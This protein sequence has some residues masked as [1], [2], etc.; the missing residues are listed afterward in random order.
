MTFDKWRKVPIKIRNEF[1][2]FNITNAQEWLQGQEVPNV[3][4]VGPYVFYETREKVNY[5][6]N[7]NNIMT[8]NQSRTWTFSDENANSL[9]DRIFHLNVPLAAAIN[10]PATLP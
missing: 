7:S 8:Y 2:L 3:E 9:N 10:F 4:Q 6:L 1:Y 5:S